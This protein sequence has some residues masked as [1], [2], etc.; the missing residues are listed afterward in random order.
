MDISLLSLGLWGRFFLH[1]T[2]FRI[3][4]KRGEYH[5]SVAK[6]KSSDVMVAIFSCVQRHGNNNSSRVYSWTQR[7]A[8]K[9]IIGKVENNISTTYLTSER[10]G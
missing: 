5:S 1:N 3:I 7:T 9:M 6:G 2:V 10:S 4:N 8:E